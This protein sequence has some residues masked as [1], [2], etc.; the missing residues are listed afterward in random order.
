[1]GFTSFGCIPVTSLTGS[2]SPC[3]EPNYASRR[4][5][6]PR[7]GYVPRGTSGVCI[8]QVFEASPHAT[9]T[10]L[11]VYDGSLSYYRTTVLLENIYDRW[12]KVNVIHDMN[13]STV[14]IYIDGQLKLVAPG[15]GEA[16][17]YF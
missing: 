14:K 9:T 10:A 16:T 15:R 6:H 4:D 17:H 13:T 11:V 8:M 1:M 12:F 5:S 2:G 3:H 7:Y